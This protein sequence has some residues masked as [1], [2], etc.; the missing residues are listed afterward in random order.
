MRVYLPESSDQ[1]QV[2]SEVTVA[3]RRIVTQKLTLNDDIVDQVL[4]KTK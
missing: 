1:V 4:K 3:K 2:S